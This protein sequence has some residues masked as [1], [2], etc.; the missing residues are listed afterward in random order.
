MT[1]AET[2]KF[3]IVVKQLIKSEKKQIRSLLDEI[4]DRVSVQ[5]KEQKYRTLL[6][7]YAC[8]DV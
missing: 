7:R 8:K 6:E 5:D 4:L 2:N 1:I 3:Y